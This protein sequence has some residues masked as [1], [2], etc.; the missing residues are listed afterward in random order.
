MAEAATGITLMIEPG[1]YACPFANSR[2][3]RVHT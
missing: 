3:R 2:S 1:E